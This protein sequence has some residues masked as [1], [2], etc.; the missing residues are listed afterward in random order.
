MEIGELP[1]RI[2][3][4][5]MSQMPFALVLMLGIKKCVDASSNEQLRAIAHLVFETMGAA[6]ACLVLFRILFG[7]AGAI[8]G[9]KIPV[10]LGAGVGLFHGYKRVKKS[11]GAVD[12]RK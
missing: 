7:P 5:A 2:L 11:F 9:W 4:A 10:F 12:H 8:D 1:A 6:I 3:L